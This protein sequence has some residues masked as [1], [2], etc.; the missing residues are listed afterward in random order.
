MAHPVVQSFLNDLA[1]QGKSSVTLRGYQADLKAFA[2]W[3]QQTYGEPFDPTTIVREDVRSWRAYLLSV[4]RCK[5]A[6]ASSSAKGKGR[7]IPGSATE[8]RSAAGLA[9]VSGSTS[10]GCR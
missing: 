6:T 2:V 3:V 1:R 5:P 8:C 7:E 4:R 9:G 10:E